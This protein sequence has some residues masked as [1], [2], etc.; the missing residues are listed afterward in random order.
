VRNLEVEGIERLADGKPGIGEGADNAPPAAICGLVFEQG[1]QEASRRPPL[2]V[3]PLGEVGP[4]LLARR[5][6]QVGEHQ[7]DARGVDGDLA[8]HAATSGAQV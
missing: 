8:A 3:G 7:L 1:G 6:P 2:L 4:H 5:H